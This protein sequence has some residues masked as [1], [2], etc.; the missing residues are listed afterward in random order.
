MATRDL[1]Q[2]VILEAPPE[3][4]F[5]AWTEPDQLVQWLA[6]RADVDLASG[7]FTLHSGTPG[8]SG[9]HE[10][11]AAE[12]PHLLHL[13]WRIDPDTLTDVRLEL[14]PHEGGTRLVS[15]HRFP[16]DLQSVDPMHV[17]ELWAYHHSL[18]KTWLELGRA[19][20][21]LDPDRTPAKEIRHH[22]ELSA[23]PDR[24]W[25]A[26]TTPELIR[27]WNAF[28]PRASVDGRVGGRYSFGW[29][30]EA[31]GTDGPGEI[32]VWEKDRRLTYRWHGDPPTLVSWEIE[33][34]PGSAHGTKL[35]LVHSGFG[36]DQ[37]MLVD[38]NLGWADFLANLALLL[39][40][41]LDAGWSGEAAAG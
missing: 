38:Y 26:L 14:S 28:A 25:A 22:L 16:D 11:R 5:A 35:T 34:L 41:D 31:Q 12:A 19:A 6:V 40:R 39:E 1:A 36:V 8:A 20:C 33:P 10:V 2:F 24:V 21:R 23:P 3:R 18:L 13:G 32:T 9:S 30:G 7:R 27:R 37:N 15:R 17:H 4:V 29:S